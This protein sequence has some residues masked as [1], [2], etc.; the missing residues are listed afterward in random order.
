M[1]PTIPVGFFIR[2]KRS[3]NHS[4]EYLFQT[5]ADN[6]PKR[7]R[8]VWLEAPYPSTG[9]INRIK[10]IWWAFENRQAINH[11]TGDIH[12]VNLLLPTRR[13]ILT[14]HDCE[15]ISRH[16]G[17]KR[18]VLKWFWLVLPISKS[19]IVTTVS[20]VS[21]SDLI[22]WSRVD[23]KKILVIPNFVD[24]EF[25]KSPVS[26]QDGNRKLL[27]IGTKKNKNILRVA[28]AVQGMKVELLIVGRL[29]DEQLNHLADLDIQYS[30][31]G[32]V[33]KEELIHLYRECD[34]LVFVSTKEGFGMPILEA[35]LA[36]TPVITSNVSSMP[37]VA[38]EGAYFVDPFSVQSI[39]EGITT[40]LDDDEIRLN[41]INKGRENSKRYS[42]SRT[43]DLYSALYDKIINEYPS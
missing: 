21:K 23:E 22:G 40:V 35:Q 29:S 27:L 19:R 43:V 6:L 31:H 34:A 25:S 28:D 41:L 26:R 15:F 37:E 11:V 18:W 4:I 5:I 38:G 39:R 42:I 10:L 1:T 9:V 2:K 17:F 32:S 36:G 24:P 33:S 30:E 12:F 3:E 8:P 20:T 7:F 13:N 14:I 16:T